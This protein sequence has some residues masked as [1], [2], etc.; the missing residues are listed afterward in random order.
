MYGNRWHG[1]SEVSGVVAPGSSRDQ[2]VAKRIFLIKR[3]LLSV[4]NKF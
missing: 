1:Q 3:N 2:G 4:L